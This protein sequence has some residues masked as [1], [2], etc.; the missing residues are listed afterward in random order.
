M[1]TADLLP[2]SVKCPSSSEDHPFSASSMLLRSPPVWHEGL[3]FTT[4]NRLPP[5]LPSALS[6]G[7]FCSSQSVLRPW[8]SPSGLQSV[9]SAVTKVCCPPQKVLTGDWIRQRKTKSQQT[10][11]GSDSHRQM[12]IWSTVNSRH[13]STGRCNAGDMVCRCLIRLGRLKMG[14]VCP[15]GP[16]GPESPS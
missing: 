5:A 15:V 8:P 9:W 12:K 1:K 3:F 14:R 10:M 6:H 4:R 2:A 16:R 11:S 13:W 7:P